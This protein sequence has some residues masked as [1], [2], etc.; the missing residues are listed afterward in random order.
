MPASDTKP[1][2]NSFKGHEGK[3]SFF[4]IGI[5]KDLKLQF[6]L[7]YTK[8][9]IEKIIK[10]VSLLGTHIE[11]N[12]DLKKCHVITQNGFFLIKTSSGNFFLNSIT[13][14][15]SSIGGKHIFLVSRIFKTGYFANIG[16]ISLMDEKFNQNISIMSIFCS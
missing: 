8:E 2:R 13:K 1:I 16:V 4:T 12:T 5:I 10:L 9:I 6:P 7:T 3:S 14:K 11:E 15:K